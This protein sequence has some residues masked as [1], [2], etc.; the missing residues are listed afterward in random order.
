MTAIVTEQGIGGEM[1][2]I[3]GF[4]KIQWSDIKRT[5]LGM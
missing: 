5:Y 4:I 1:P 2:L 3:S